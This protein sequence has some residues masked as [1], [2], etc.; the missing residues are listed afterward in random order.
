MSIIP[1]LYLKSVLITSIQTELTDGE[2]LQF[3]HELLKKNHDLNAKGIILDVS[4][5]DVIDSYMAKIITDTMSMVMLQG[6]KL[7]L[8]GVQ[9]VVASTLVDM[10]VVLGSMKMFLNLDQAFCFLTTKEVA[11]V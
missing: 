2:I 6:S 10:G 1:I 3:Q 5:L 8:C 4:S 11:Q 7:V 9:P